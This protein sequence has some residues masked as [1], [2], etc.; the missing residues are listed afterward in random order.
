MELLIFQIFRDST[1][2]CVRVT[3]LMGGGPTISA[4]STSSGRI[5]FTSTKTNSVAGLSI[6]PL[7]NFSSIPIH[8][9][10]TGS[11]ICGNLSIQKLKKRLLRFVRPAA[12]DSIS[13][14]SRALEFG[15]QEMKWNIIQ[16][17]KVAW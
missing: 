1:I 17:M 13:A 6:P 14:P 10:T 2:V 5:Y 3:V 9:L 16:M 7:T 12:S 15:G 8:S 11:G 4:N